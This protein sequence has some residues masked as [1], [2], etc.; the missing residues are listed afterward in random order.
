[1]NIYQNVRQL[2]NTRYSGKLFFPCPMN[3][4]GS[5]S[6]RPVNR[7]TPLQKDPS[8]AGPSWSSARP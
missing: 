4:P 5:G 2:N 7:E 1:M 6:L 3:S 8:A